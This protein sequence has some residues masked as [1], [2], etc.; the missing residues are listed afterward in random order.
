MTTDAAVLIF[1]NTLFEAAPQAAT[2]ASLKYV[3][4][5]EP[6]YF[7]DPARRIWAN[8]NK[9][10]FLRAAMRAHAAELAAAHGPGRVHYVLGLKEVRELL[11]RLKPRRVVAW[12]PCDDAVRAKYRS[13][14]NIFEDDTPGFLLAG[15]DLDALR[16]AGVARMSKVYKRVQ[17]RLGV[18]LGPSQDSANRT[19]MP[20][21]ARAPTPPEYR[22]AFHDEA[23]AYASRLDARHVGDP[24]HLKYSPVT[25]AQ[26]RAHLKFFVRRRLRDF[27]PFQDFTRRDEIYLNH[28]NISHLLNV[29]LLTP[30]EVAVAVVRT[31]MEAEI[32]AQSVEGFLR[33]LLGWREF[34]RYLYARWKDS[35]LPP[36]TVASAR[37]RFGDPD[38]DFDPATWRSGVAAIDAEIDK[39][40]RTGYAHHIVR[41]MF[42]LNYFKLSETHPA[43]IHRWFMSVCSLD[44]YDWVMY[45]NIAAMGH[46]SAV[47]HMQK[48]YLS[49][50][51]YARKMSDYG[52]N[53]PDP[54][55][56]ELWDALFYKYLVRRERKLAGGERVYLR[57][58]AAFR[59]F[60]P[61]KQARL[62]NLAQVRCRRSS[63]PRPLRTSHPRRGPAP[64]RR[65]ASPATTET[66][67]AK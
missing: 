40:A 52:R 22:S 19:R 13:V 34:M 26:A 42:F 64:T 6:L 35:I 33:Q 16:R 11:A 8:R 65:A 54:A 55:G 10:A 37:S 24:A 29:G 49:T 61:A 28:A 57:N 59:R 51:A 9:V 31:S 48:P 63:Q 32:P 18:S 25:R 20:K 62:M 14:V 66:T 23:V 46:Y 7:R 12:D 67:T 58:L 30:A 27:G 36:F 39:C 44:A 45:S 50:S 4:V 1:P 2:A 41:L 17:E 53:Q 3:L 15:A 56:A 43:D 60:S 21:E 47:P 38:P 5:E